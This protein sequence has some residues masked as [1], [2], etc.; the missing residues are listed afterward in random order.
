M[1]EEV[2]LEELIKKRKGKKLIALLVKPDYEKIDVAGAKIMRLFKQLLWAMD[3]HDFK[4][5]ESGFEWDQ[6]SEMLLWLF[7]NREALPELKKLHG[8]RKIDRKE[9]ISSFREKYGKRVK[10][11]E[12]RFYAELPR[13]YRLAEQL[14]KD[15]LKDKRFQEFKILEVR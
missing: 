7:T 11:D 6:K 10:A 13:K 2:T 1:E 5:F 14:L 9:F 12:K 4:I 15:V 3:K 8:P